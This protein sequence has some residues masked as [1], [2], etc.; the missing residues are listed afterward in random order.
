MRSAV[1][2]GALVLSVTFIPAPQ[3]AWAQATPA[4]V[5]PPLVTLP[6]PDF[7]TVPNVGGDNE[8]NPA[9]TESGSNVLAVPATPGGGG[10]ISKCM[11]IGCLSND[12]KE[13]LYQLCRA[14]NQQGVNVDDKSLCNAIGS[15]KAAQ[16]GIQ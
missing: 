3:F 14:L 13:E 16:L 8:W 10:W 7:A 4:P 1:L 5:A 9:L 6:E 12:E 2:Y 11:G 15:W